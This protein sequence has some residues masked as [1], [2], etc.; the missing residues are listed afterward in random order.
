MESL[1]AF[2]QV[3]PPETPVVQQEAAKGGVWENIVASLTRTFSEMLDQAVS[4]IPRF[5]AMLAILI[6]GLL[7]AKLLR[8]VASTVLKKIQFDSI[9]DRTGLHEVTRGL[10][11]AQPLSIVMSQLAF[12]GAMLMFLVAAVDV[13]GMESVSGAVGAVVA[14]LPNVITA[15][16]IL[17][18]GVMAGNFARKIAQGTAERMG[19]DY[20]PAI[21]SL[22]FGAIVFLVGNVA[23]TQL[24]I[25]I[26]LVNR[27]VE[28]G[29]MACGAALALSVG[30]GTKDIARHVVA[31]MYARDS[32]LPGAVVKVGEHRGTVEAVRAVNTTITTE[33]GNVIYIPNYTLTES[34]VIQTDTET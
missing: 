19:F 20:A 22:T 6:V 4:L 14:F 27:I 21:G 33:D 24:E 7:I 16:I 1:I 9:C 34:K 5:V 28:I 10:G 2:I 18:A 32:F 11:M 17:I 23:I 13:L 29:L 30:L 25:D 31:G 26:Q 8:S 15:L 3:T 12:Y